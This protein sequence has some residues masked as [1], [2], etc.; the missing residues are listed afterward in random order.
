MPPRRAYGKRRIRSRL[1][2][3]KDKDVHPLTER[4]NILRAAGRW[5]VF[6]GERGHP[7][8]AWF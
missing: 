2:L 8:R 3:A 4:L 6:W 1:G 7:I 5:H